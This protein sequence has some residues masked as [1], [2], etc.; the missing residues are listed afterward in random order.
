MR[1]NQSVGY[2]LVLSAAFLWGTLG[3][4]YKYLNTNAQLSGIEIVFWRAIIA[5]IFTFLY[6]LLFKPDQLHFKKNNLGLFLAI[7]LFGIAGFYV[8]YIYAIT[9]IGMGIASV[10]LYS[11][12]VWV[13]V[14]G[15]LWNGERLNRRKILALILSITGSIFIANVY[16]LDQFRMSAFGLIAGLGAGIGYAAYIIL[17]KR[18]SQQGYGAWTVNAY[19]LGIG[20]MILLIFQDFS[21]LKITFMTPATLGWLVILGMVPTLGGGLAFYS[22]LKS[23]PAVNASITATFEPVVATI[24]GWWLFSENLNL[25]QIMGGI[26]IIAGVILIQL[27]QKKELNSTAGRE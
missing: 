2:L 21:Q 22:G 4:F 9:S 12:P 13:A 6:L 17:N 10:L 14:Y 18:A 7:G 26:A 24:F 15:V 1:S 19:G 16:R 8:V 25:V 27:P 23:I 3:I 20:A 11:A 5:A